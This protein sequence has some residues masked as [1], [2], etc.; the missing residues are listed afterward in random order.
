MDFTVDVVVTIASRCPRRCRGRWRVD[1]VGDGDR[2]AAR[3]SGGVGRHDLDPIR[4]Q[5][6]RHVCCPHAVVVRGDLDARDHHRRTRIGEPADHEV[7]GANDETVDDVAVEEERR[8]RG[9]AHDRG[10]RGRRRGV[11]PRPPRSCR[12]LLPPARAAARRSP[13]S[14]RNAT[15]SITATP[16]ASTPNTT[17]SRVR[18]RNR[19]NGRAIAAPMVASTA[20]MTLSR[21]CLRNQSLTRVHRR[22]QA[23]AQRLSMSTKPSTARFARPRARYLAIWSPALANPAKGPAALWAGLEWYPVEPAP[24]QTRTRVRAVTGW[25]SWAPRTWWAP[26]WWWVPRWWWALRWWSW[27]ARSSSWRM[28]SS[29]WRCSWSWRCVVAVVVVAPCV[30][31]AVR[32]CSSPDGSSGCSAPP[33]PASRSWWSRASWSWARASSRCSTNPPASSSWRPGSWSAH[34]RRRGD[35]GLRRLLGRR[36]RRGRVDDVDDRERE[37]TGIADFVGHGHLDDVRPELEGNLSRPDAVRIGDRLD[38]GD[39]DQRPGFGEPA[40]PDAVRAH[41]D[42]V[43][44]AGVER[45]RRRSGVLRDRGDG[46][47]RPHRGRGPVS[48]RRLGDHLRLVGSRSAAVREHGARHRQK[49]TP[50]RPSI[51]PGRPTQSFAFTPDYRQP[52]RVN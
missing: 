14:E 34:C 18:L 51:I 47:R 29:S 48:R 36:R 6:Q 15:A 39:G 42:P 8:G 11:V 43:V 22:L 12:A 40:H 7:I 9:V 20:R 52:R 17:L 49:A 21:E 32:W 19:A 31:V 23:W 1:V 28:R 3:V 33:D 37:A 30:V 25:W 44:Q 46:R 27:A 45:E 24:S 35:D 10:E 26:R 4:A 2:E 13:E 41:L 5:R 50:L 16:V 38:A